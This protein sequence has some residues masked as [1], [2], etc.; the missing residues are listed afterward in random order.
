MTPLGDRP[1]PLPGSSTLPALELPTTKRTGRGRSQLTRDRF[2]TLNAF[3]DCSLGGLTR[4]ELATWL[5]LYRD[6]RN[7][8]ASTSQ[9]DI[10]RRAG[11]SVR[12]VKS[13]VRKLT[14]VG[15]LIVVFR[16]GLNRGPSRYRVMP[17][18]N[19]AAP[20]PVQ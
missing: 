17:L 1:N 15:L 14:V 19:R 13:A 9:A 10:A 11:L 6:T 4:A 7:G 8:T 3:V 16:G 18:G 12:S 2:A 20:P 5:V